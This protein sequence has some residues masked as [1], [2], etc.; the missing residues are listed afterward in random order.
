MSTS[1]NNGMQQR[2]TLK[3]WTWKKLAGLK[4]Y[5]VLQHEQKMDRR[6]RLNERLA[7]IQQDMYAKHAGLTNPVPPTMG[8]DDV[9]VG[10]SH[11]ETHYHESPRESTGSKWGPIIGAAIL[12]AGIAAG[13]AGLNAL[14]S[15]GTDTDTQYNLGGPWVE[16]ED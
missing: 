9:Q 10:D 5:N 2:K 3:E 11:N 6:A 4:A 16:V 14:R 15:D 7:I 13:A 12:G 8:D 1:T